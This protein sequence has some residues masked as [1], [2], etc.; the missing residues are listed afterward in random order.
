MKRLIRRALA[1]LLVVGAAVA[2]PAQQRSSEPVLSLPDALSLTRTDQPRIEAYEREAQA[3]EQA[4]V[5]ARSLPDPQL[6]VGIQNYPVTGLNA[7]SPT[8]DEMTM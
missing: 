7:P 8:A 6:T 3:S 4:A 1:G 2:A 5:A